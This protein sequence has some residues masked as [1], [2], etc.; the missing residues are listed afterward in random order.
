MGR[1]FLDVLSKTLGWT[2]AKINGEL[3]K[4]FG[5]PERVD[6]VDF[7]QFPPSPLGSECPDLSPCLRL[8]LNVTL[9]KSLTRPFLN[10][11]LLGI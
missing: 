5:T 4:A 3:R 6:P 10:V 2:H 9:T 1:F 11:Q 7:A 8:I